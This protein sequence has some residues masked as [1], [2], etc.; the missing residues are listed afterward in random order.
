MTTL[1]D[2]LGFIAS[3]AT[4][5]DIDRIFDA[6]KHRLRALRAVR[7]ADVDLGSTVK[8]VNISPKALNGLHGTVQ[9]ISGKRADVM[10]DAPSTNRLRFARTRY[11][12]A[13]P[14]DANEYLLTGIPLSCCEPVGS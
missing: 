7:A 11:A 10:L 14:A 13:V 5:A 1:S 4:E 3:E 8:T 2:T 12:S 9:A 6:A